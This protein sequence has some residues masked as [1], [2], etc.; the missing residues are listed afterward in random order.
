MHY[1]VNTNS[2]KMQYSQVSRMQRMV[3]GYTVR[4]R[5]R[6]FQKMDKITDFPQKNWTVFEQNMMYMNLHEISNVSNIFTKYL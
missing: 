3:L 4:K 1:Q 5:I 6:L 2:L